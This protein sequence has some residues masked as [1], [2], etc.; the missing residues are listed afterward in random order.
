MAKIHILDVNHTPVA[1]EM[2]RM[3]C[4]VVVPLNPLDGIREN[5]PNLCPEC[6]MVYKDLKRAEARTA[7]SYA[8]ASNA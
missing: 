8:V 5:D 2:I 4:G 7:F 3:N 1:G 6:L